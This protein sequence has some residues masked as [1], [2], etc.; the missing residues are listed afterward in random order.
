MRTVI[1]VTLSCAQAFAQSQL[2]AFEAA[3]IRANH[4]GAPSGGD[5]R[6]GGQ[7]RLT[8]LSLR[9]LIASA[10]QVKAYAVAGGPAWLDSERFDVIAK[11]PAKTPTLDLQLML[12]SLLVERFRLVVHSGE[13]TMRVYALVAEKTGARLPTSADA[14]AAGGCSGQ[15]EE[16]LAH[17]TCKNTSMAMFAEALPAMSPH[18]VDAPVVDSTGLAGRYDFQLSWKPRQLQGRDGD[19]PDLTIFDALRKQLGLRLE[20]RKMAVPAIFIDSIERLA[21]DR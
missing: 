13:R 8:A 14:S 5:L 7:L 6:M 4:S 9:L 16:G 21:D 1:W 2:P 18:Y 17:R 11:A 19:T 12:R 15:R 20:A 10:W 3:E